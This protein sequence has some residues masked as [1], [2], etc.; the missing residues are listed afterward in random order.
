MLIP[1]HLVAVADTVLR[2]AR[3]VFDRAL[4][5]L[6]RL[7]HLIQG[8]LVARALE[9]VNDSRLSSQAFSATVDVHAID[10][11]VVIFVKV[12]HVVHH[13]IEPASSVHVVQTS[14]HHRESLEESAIELLHWLGVHFDLHPRTPVHDELGRHFCLVAVDVLQTEEELP[15]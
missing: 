15:V 10:Q 4:S 1:L 11:R 2:L 12:D 9:W 14:D 5:V 13:L 7:G 3:N 6:F 8:T